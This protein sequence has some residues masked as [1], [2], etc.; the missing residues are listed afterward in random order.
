[1]KPILILSLAGML[2]ACSLKERTDIEKNPK[3]SLIFGYAYLSDR[4][5][6]DANSIDKMDIFIFDKVGRFIKSETATKENI[7]DPQGIT[8]LSGV[9]EDDYTVVSFAN[10]DR[11]VL[12]KMVPGEST[13]SGFRLAL[14][15][16]CTLTSGDRLFHHIGKFH[17]ARGYPAVRPIHL[18]KLYYLI[19]LT[20]KGLNSI[21][22][23]GKAVSV[24]ISGI[25][26]G[27]DAAGNCLQKQTVIVPELRPESEGLIGIFPVNRFGE[28]NRVEI[29]LKADDITV[30]DLPL[31]DYLSENEIGIDFEKDRDIVIPVVVDLT[32]GE[33]T[34]T[35]N[36]WEIDAKQN[37]CLGD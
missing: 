30:F 24:E 29:T 35:V 5:V 33:V 31:S 9:P 21:C 18:N 13:L 4:N 17:I 6:Y 22:S 15:D 25:T 7:G 26:A 37:P 10:I 1:M 27:F 14:P 20:V 16:N 32:A 8:I 12:P 3:P 34:I 2:C 36:G 11:A 28:D 19:D 23:A